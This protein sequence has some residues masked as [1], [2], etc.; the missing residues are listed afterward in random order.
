MSPVFRRVILLV[1]DG[2]G[3]GALPDAGRFGDEGAHTLLHVADGAGG[4]SLPHLAALGLGCIAPVPGLAP[5]VAPAAAFGRMAELSR[6]KD[7]STGHWELAGLPTL[8][9]YATFPDGFPPEIIA[10]FAAATGFEPLG[11]IA[12][13]GTDIIA[14]LGAQ[15]MHSGR[16]IV[17]T[18][19]DSV[20]QIAAHESIIPPAQL[21]DLCRQ[22]RRILDPWR[23]GRV[24]ARPFDGDAVN[25]FQ[26]TTRRHDFAMPPP[27]PTLL[28]RLSEAGHSVVGVGKIGDIFA[29]CGLTRSLPTHGNDDGMRC[30]LQVLDSVDSGM[31][32]V[33]LVDFDMM[34]G[35]RLDVAGFSDALQA[36]DVWLPQLQRQ[37]RSDDLLILTADH[38][39]DP[40]INGTDHTREYVPL[41]V[42]H[43]TI[44]PCD[45]GERQSF[46][47]VAATI[48]EN[49]GLMGG[50]GESFLPQLL[51]AV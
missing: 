14:R 6:G 36:F 42:W 18:S 49:F 31:I 12:A 44:R 5:V 40:Q 41:L 1:L 16:P 35:H 34:Y 11:N 33:N 17:Y 2:V 24:I 20:F 48:S 50:E 15:H 27:A 26:R 29:G 43:H 38:G 30:T 22:A 21:Y 19:A 3:V 46:S 39:C 45:L 28:D 13:S 25:G 10:A 51:A 37:M 7:T 9:P 8:H 32:F 47:D 4:L 23:V